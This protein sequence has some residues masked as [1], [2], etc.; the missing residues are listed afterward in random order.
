MYW[1]ISAG[2]QGED[3]LG[4]GDHNAACHGEHTVGA[5]AG[6][7]TLEGESDLQ[8]TEAQQDDTHRA[9]EGENKLG[10]VVDYS[11]GIICRQRSGG[12]AQAQDEHGEDGEYTVCAVIGHI[13]LFQGI[14]PPFQYCLGG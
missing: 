12:K 10:Q 14:F 1:N 4:K 3:L 8:D 11:E 7:M 6:V 9:D 5:L 2:D 13:V